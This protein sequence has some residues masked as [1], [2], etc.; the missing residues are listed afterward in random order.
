MPCLIE[1]SPG[2]AVFSGH[3][4][5]VGVIHILRVLEALW[6]SHAEP[7]LPE[8][9]P[10]LFCV[11]SLPSVSALTPGFKENSLQERGW[12][13]GHGDSTHIQ[14]LEKMADLELCQSYS[15]LNCLLW[16]T[17]SV[18]QCGHIWGLLPGCGGVM[19]A[20]S[21]L[22]RAPSSQ[23]YLMKQWL[24]LNNGDSETQAGDLTKAINSIQRR[25]G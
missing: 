17:A 22:S 12:G 7:P 3:T 2:A 19:A 16:F 13:Y 23:I 9:S 21:M 20:L 11:P 4:G 25:Q 8:L 5:Q 24:P 18:P 6:G 10:G 15:W 14:V 1:V